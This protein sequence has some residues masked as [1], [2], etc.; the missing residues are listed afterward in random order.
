M[1]K[2]QNK[3]LV[4]A[5]S[6]IALGIVTLG[7]VSCLSWQ[8]QLSS[9]QRDHQIRLAA[10]R[11]AK[12]TSDQATETGHAA[13][14]HRSGYAAIADQQSVSVWFRQKLVLRVSK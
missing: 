14:I 10:A 12:E 9:V 1:K 7:I 13:K 3:G 2:W 5:D 6:L 11:L 8:Q 4:M